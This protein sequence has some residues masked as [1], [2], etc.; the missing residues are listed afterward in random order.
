[1]ARRRL[2]ILL[3]C[4]GFFASRA[5]AVGHHS[6]T[7]Y[8]DT[9]RQI[10]LKGPVDSV[11]WTNPHMFLHIEVR[12]DGGAATKWAIETDSPN[13]LSRAGWTRTT[14]HFGDEVTATGYPSKDGKPA[15]RLVTLALADG[16]KLKG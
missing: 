14:L 13:V 2:H 15:L 5:P 16:R 7:A 12:G 4:I 3:V 10:T 1:M 6:V 9:S 8:Y 11:E